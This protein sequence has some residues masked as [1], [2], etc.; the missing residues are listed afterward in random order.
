MAQLELRP[1]CSTTFETAG[2]STV[3]FYREQLVVV[4]QE[5]WLFVYDQK[6]QKTVR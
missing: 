1:V 2:P 3:L 4:R 6:L 5:T